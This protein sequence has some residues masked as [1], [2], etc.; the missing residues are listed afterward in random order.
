MDQSSDGQTSFRA[1]AILESE[2]EQCHFCDWL[3]K[4]YVT[5]AVT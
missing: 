4:S 2:S 3:E 1:H 5:A